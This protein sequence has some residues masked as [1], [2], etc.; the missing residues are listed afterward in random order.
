MK[1]YK[2]ERD[3]DESNLKK[4][5]WVGSAFCDGIIVPRLPIFKDN[6]EY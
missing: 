1:K 4:F 6:T 5:E 2:A 3:L